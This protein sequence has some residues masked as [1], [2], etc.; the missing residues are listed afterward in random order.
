VASLKQQIGPAH[1]HAPHALPVEVREGAAVWMKSPCLGLCEHAP[2]VFVQQAG[3][4]PREHLYGP[5]TADDVTEILAG[6]DPIDGARVQDPLQQGDE[7]R[8]LQRI[9]RVDP[10][11]LAAYRQSRGYEALDKAL[12]MGP[13][14]V[15]AEVSAS[16]LM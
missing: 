1:G 5:V 11:S 15:I 9:G 14:A 10:G 4:P 12:A 2:A 6:A 8:A 3:A 7:G 13:A 16:K